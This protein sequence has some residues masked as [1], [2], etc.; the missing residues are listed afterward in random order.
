MAFA[1]KVAWQCSLYI[2]ATVW[3]AL[4]AAAVHPQQNEQQLLC[5]RGS[6]CASAAAAAAAAVH[7]RQHQQQ[8][9]CITSSRYSSATG[10]PS[11]AVYT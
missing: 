1:V 11:G 5:V 9:L 3:L 6:C 4:A 2:G 10:R 7:Q 8:L